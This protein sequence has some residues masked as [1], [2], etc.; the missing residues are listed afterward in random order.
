VANKNPRSPENQHITLAEAL[1]SIPSVDGK[2][3]ATLFDHGTLEIKMYAPV[4]KDLQTP[5]KRDEVYII[6]RGSGVFLNNG[7]RSSVRAGD[8]LFVPAGIEHRFEEFSDDFATWVLFYG[9][10]GGESA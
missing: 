6:A 3:S 2:P 8:F 4:G 1:A 9:P 5:H 7:H 10:E